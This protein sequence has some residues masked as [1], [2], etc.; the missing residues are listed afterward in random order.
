MGRAGLEE[1]NLRRV[2]IDADDLIAQVGE[3]RPGPQPD[4]P[5]SND[6]DFHVASS[7]VSIPASQAAT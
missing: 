3:D 4:I 7:R 1:I 2:D 6:R 5:R